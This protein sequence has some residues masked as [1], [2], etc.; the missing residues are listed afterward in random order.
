MFCYVCLLFGEKTTS[1][2]MIISRTQKWARK[3]K[4]V[5]EWEVAMDKEIHFMKNVKFRLPCQ[6]KK[7]KLNRKGNWKALGFN[8]ET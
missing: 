7:R 2:E 5:Y 6:K 8:H 4:E 1:G 3:T